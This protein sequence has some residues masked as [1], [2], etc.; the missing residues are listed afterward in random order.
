MNELGVRTVPYS[1]VIAYLLKRGTKESSSIASNIL[2][3]LGY[4]KR[5][6]VMN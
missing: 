6:D 4:A 5:M 2:D 1:E 3:I